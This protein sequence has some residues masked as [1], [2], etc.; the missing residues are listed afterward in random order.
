MF[1]DS[2]SDQSKIDFPEIRSP[3]TVVD[4]ET[5]C[6]ENDGGSPDPVCKELVLAARGRSYGS[7]W[8]YSCQ[9]REVVVV[10]VWKVQ[11]E[12]VVGLDHGQ[13]N[14]PQSCTG[15]GDHV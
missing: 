5:C 1:Q 7:P 12:V 10:M 2:C 11:G 6:T 4:S 14:H 13:C 9:S 8:V 3:E 15:A